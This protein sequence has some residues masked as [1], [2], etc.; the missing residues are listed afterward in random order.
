MRN[1]Q[2]CILSSGTCT[3]ECFKAVIQWCQTHYSMLMINAQNSD[4]ELF[5]VDRRKRRTARAWTPCGSSASWSCVW[6][7][8]LV[9]PVIGWHVLRRFLNSW[10]D[11]SQFSLKVSYSVVIKFAATLPMVN[12]SEQPLL[13]ALYSSTGASSQA[14]ICE[15]AIHS[16]PK[17]KDSRK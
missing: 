14:A 1:R 16:L 17:F 6:I 7:S 10:L 15:K 4:S 12:W 13:R 2:M 11:S 9:S 5:V 3:L 8:A